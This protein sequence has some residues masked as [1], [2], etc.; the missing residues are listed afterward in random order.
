M[1]NLATNK[2]PIMDEVKLRR[3]SNRKVVDIRLDEKRTGV[4]LLF[5]TDPAEY[6]PVV[7]PSPLHLTWLRNEACA[8]AMAINN[9][10]PKRD[11]ATGD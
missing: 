4:L 7:A 5:D 10:R 9:P 11:S 6:L 3:A 8:Y 2:N 1:T